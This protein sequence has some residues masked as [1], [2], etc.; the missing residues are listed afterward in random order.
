MRLDNYVADVDAHAECNA[1][2]FRIADCKVVDAGLELH[3][4]PNR[5]DCAR[6]LRQESVPGVLDDTAAVVG[7]CR[8]D[9][10]RQERRQ[11]G[12]R[13]LLVMVHQSRVA[14]Y[15]SRNYGRQPASNPAWMR[16]GHGPRSPSR[17]IMY[18]GAVGCHRDTTRSRANTDGHASR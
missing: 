11:L 4:S 18:D 7:N 13:S 16:F 6:K 3:S 10:V 17:S 12:M 2:V 1:L 9:N 15:V 8:G 5:F 14:R